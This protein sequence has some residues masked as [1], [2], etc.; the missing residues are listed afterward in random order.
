MRARLTRFETGDQGTMGILEAPGFECRTMELP[1]RDNQPN[2][3]CIPPGK[4]QCQV[5]YSRRF[6]KEFYGIKHVPGRSWILFHAGNVAGDKA[7]GLA[8]HSEGCILLGD[9]H[10][11]L[12]GQDAVL[13]SRPTVRRFMEHMEKQP[14]G[15]EIVW[16]NGGMS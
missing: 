10:G 5:R 6:Q 3:S 1:W 13:L 8:S 16:A 4:Y 12:Q 9:R 15:L 2:I 14:F 11:K 7:K